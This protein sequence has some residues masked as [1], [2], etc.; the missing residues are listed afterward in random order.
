MLRYQADVRSLVFMA[1]AAGTL[2]FL[3]RF[4]STLSTPLWVLCYTLQLLMAVIVSTMV[5]NHQ[6]LPMWTVKW[7]NVFTDN[8]LTVFYGF[9]VFAWIPTHNSNHHIHINKEPDYTKT[10]M[11]SEKNNLLT[12][13]SYPSISGVKQ[14]K[15]VGSYFLNLYK[16]DRRKFFFHLLQI[17]SLVAWVLIALIIDWEK[18]ILYVII[19][20][21]LSLFTV[22]IFNYI[23]HIHADEESEFNHSR[24]MTG[25]VLNFLLLN[26]GLHTVHHISPGLHWSKLREKH[27]KIADKIDPRLNENNF[28]WYLFRVYFLGLFSASFRTQNMRMERIGNLEPERV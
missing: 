14:Q 3:W 20:Q 24:N 5:H 10:Y 6:H 11:V 2:I 15:A 8:F 21:Q 26:N 19:P 27:D 18:A 23:Q 28:A 25:S 12:L 9:P 1:I 13:L 17:I 16:S 7:L 4:G 22:L